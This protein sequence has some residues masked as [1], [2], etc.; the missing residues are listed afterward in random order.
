MERMVIV[1]SAEGYASGGV[2]DNSR[3]L[4]QT[5]VPT[6]L[7]YVGE[8]SILIL[9]G[10]DVHAINTALALRGFL[11]KEHKGTVSAL[12]SYALNTIVQFEIY[13]SSIPESNEFIILIPKESVINAEVGKRE[14]RE[15]ELLTTSFEPLEYRN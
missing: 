1:K 6:L 3:R 15:C 13:R 14:L 8:R 4:I 9:Y 11:S 12:C 10:Q 7:N 5:I 2:P